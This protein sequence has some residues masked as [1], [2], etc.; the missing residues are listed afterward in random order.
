MGQA[1]QTA[2]DLLLVLQVEDTVYVGEN[3]VVFGSARVSEMLR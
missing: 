2:V 1:H 3:A